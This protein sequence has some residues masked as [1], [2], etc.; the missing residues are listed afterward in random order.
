MKLITSLL[1][2]LSIFNT[3]FAQEKYL[4]KSGSISFFSHS[5]AEDIKA[6]N[7]QVLSIINTAN[8]EVAIAILMKSFHFKKSLMQEHFN[9]NYVESDKFPKATFKGAIVDYENI[10]KSGTQNITIKGALTLHGA[11][12]QVETQAIINWTDAVISLDGKF[13][14]DVADY[15]IDIPSVVKNNIAKSIEISFKLNH[16]LY[17]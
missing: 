14:V 1:L 13:S 8:G 3:S 16:K 12:K 7:K 9:E 11:T 10:S 15:N 2:F 17:K 5:P 4:T 6:D